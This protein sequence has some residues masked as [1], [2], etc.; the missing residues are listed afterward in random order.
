MVSIG[1]TEFGVDIGGGVGY[2]NTDNKDG[3]FIIE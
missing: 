2:A 3:N 1:G